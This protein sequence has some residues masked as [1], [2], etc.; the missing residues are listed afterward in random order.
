MLDHL[1]DVL[2]SPTARCLKK[3]KKKEQNYYQQQINSTVKDKRKSVYY[4]TV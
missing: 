4:L 2:Q 1:L 3:G